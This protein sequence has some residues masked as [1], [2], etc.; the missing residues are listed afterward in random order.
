MLLADFF[1]VVVDVFVAAYN[2]VCFGVDCAFYNFVV[3]WVFFDDINSGCG[4]YD[5][6]NDCYS[7]YCLLCF[8]LFVFYFVLYFLVLEYF[9]VFFEDGF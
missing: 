4:F 7:C 5:M 8:L 3:V 6:C 9:V 2:V 1:F